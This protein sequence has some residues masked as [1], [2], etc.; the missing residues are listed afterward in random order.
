MQTATCPL[1]QFVFRDLMAQLIGLCCCARVV[2][3][4]KRS[5][6][7][8]LGAHAYQPVPESRDPYRVNLDCMFVECLFVARQSVELRLREI[9]A[10]ADDSYQTISIYL[11]CAALGSH[12]ISNARLN[13]LNPPPHLVKQSSA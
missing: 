11:D 5:H 2:P 1:V 10:A 8:A 6:G 12:F 7:F 13:L 3:A 4:I 9:K